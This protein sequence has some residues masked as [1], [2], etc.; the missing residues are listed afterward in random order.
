MQGIAFGIQHHPLV[1]EDEMSKSNT[2]TADLG[3]AAD[4]L[5]KAADI[6]DNIAG[7]DANEGGEGKQ[8]KKRRICD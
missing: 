5:R 8:P 2:K 1:S 3:K 4:Y 6:I 7:S